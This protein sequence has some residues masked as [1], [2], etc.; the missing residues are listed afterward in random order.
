MTKTE[1]KDLIDYYNQCK[2][3]QQT[4][5]KFKCAKSTVYYHVSVNGKSQNVERNRRFRSNTEPL[6]IKFEKF[7]NRTYT[8]KEN[9]IQNSI[10]R[11]IY[12]KISDFQRKG[13][14]M[15][16]NKFTYEDLINKIGT[17]PKCYLTGETIDLSNPKTY[18]L[19]H[20]I[21]ISKGGTN[22]LDNLGICTRE[23][24]IAKHNMT[25]EQFIEL[26][27]KVVANN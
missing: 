6:K 24:N 27:K 11:A 18:Q 22:T 4:C 16:N 13:F 19:D 10:K 9:K 1:I 2:S 8:E 15:S 23:A 12:D 20:I 17:N 21:P 7:I 14:T 5:E 26:C 25:P 3:Y